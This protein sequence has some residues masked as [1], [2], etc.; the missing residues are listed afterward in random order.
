[1]CF[2]HHPNPMS[3]LWS[4]SKFFTLASK[5]INCKECDTRWASQS[6]VVATICCT[7]E[8]V[9]ASF[10]EFVTETRDKTHNSEG[11]GLLLQI[12]SFEFV[13]ALVVFHRLLSCMKNLSDGLRPTNLDLAKAARSHLYHYWHTST[14]LIG[15]RMEKGLFV[16]KRAFYCQHHRWSGETK[17][18]LLK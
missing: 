16:S 13:L 1:M 9:M 12:Q 4:I 7:Y 5:F 11:R 6:H 8:A 14:V 3:Y 10:L 15:F 18:Y 17:N 2:Y